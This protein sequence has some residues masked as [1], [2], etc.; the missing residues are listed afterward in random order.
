MK[1][2]GNI[3]H[4]HIDLK[5]SSLKD[6]IKDQERQIKKDKSKTD[7]YPTYNSY[8]EKLIQKSKEMIEILK[9]KKSKGFNMV[10]E[11]GFSD[12]DG[13]AIGS[14][15]RTERINVDRNNLKVLVSG[16]E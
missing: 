5:I 12:N 10:A 1:E 11:A 13:S 2:E 8:R 16:D 6:L 3:G 7:I 15:I 4:Q 9:F 14:T